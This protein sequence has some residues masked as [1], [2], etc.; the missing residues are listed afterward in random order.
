MRRSR[1]SRYLP[2]AMVGILGILTSSVLL[3]SSGHAQELRKSGALIVGTN[4]ECLQLDPHKSAEKACRTLIGRN[5]YSGLVRFDEKMNIL[6][7]LASSWT[8]S[9]DGTT[10]TFK[11]REGVKFH[12]GSELTMEDVK[13]SF[14]R[15]VNRETGSPYARF[16]K[17]VK[18]IKITKNRE[19][20][21]E[22]SDRFAPFLTNLANPYVVVVSRQLVEKPGL[23]NAAIGTGPFKLAE[24]LP[25]QRVVLE[26]NADYFIKDAP[27]LSR[28]TF[29]IMPDDSAR[30]AALRAGEIDFMDTVPGEIVDSLKGIP[31]IKIAGGATGNW[32]WVMFNTQKPPFSNVKVRQ[33]IGWA[34]NRQDI[35]DAAALGKGEPLNGGPIPSFHWAA[36]DQPCFNPDPAKA[37]KLLAESGHPKGL[38]MT[39][40]TSSTFPWMVSSVLAIQD[41]L[42]SVGVNVKIET[43]E[44]GVLLAKM[45][46][47]EF[48]VAMSGF[49]GNED[50]DDYFS[51]SFLTTSPHN[52]GRFSDAGIDQLIKEGSQTFDHSTRKA[53]YQSLQKKLC[54]VSSTLFLYSGGEFSAMKASVQGYSFLRNGEHQLLRAWVEPK[55]AQ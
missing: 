54:E 12:N 38:E 24:R 25:A 53:I 40:S 11:I 9:A 5:V 32:R 28:V 8:Q 30:M 20:V 14:E 7:D 45:Q 17:R 50:P 4:T 1:R 27:H 19:L 26:R 23:S 37:K 10:W 21:F 15:I 18:S 41:Q 29:R 44:W 52:Y 22:L 33:A 39:I 47:G 35:M 42:K 51:R 55:K 6:P 3:V 31:Q 43:V 46:K 2:S 16:F 48:Q 49:S 13:F 34:L 36:L